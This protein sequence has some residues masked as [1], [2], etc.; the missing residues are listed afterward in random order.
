MEVTLTDDPSGDLLSEAEDEL[1]DAVFAAH[2]HL[3]R[4][5]MVDFV[6]TLPEWRDPEGGPFG[7]TTARVCN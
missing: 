6:H 2:G 5:K 3:S 7:L 1:L 4:W